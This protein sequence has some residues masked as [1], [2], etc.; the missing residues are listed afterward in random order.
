MISMSSYITHLWKVLIVFLIL[1]NLTGCSRVELLNS[2]ES[3]DTKY[4]HV[5][6]D[7]VFESFDTA[8]KEGLKD[9]FSPNVR[10]DNP[11]LDEQ[12]TSFFEEY[13]SPTVIEEISYSTS[14]G[15]H[16]DH[17]N[18]RTELY[19]SYDIII[20]SGEIRYYIDVELVSRDDFDPDNEGI[21]TLNIS[22]EE[23]HESKYFVNYYSNEDRGGD[24]P[25]FYYQDSTEMRDDIRWIEGMPWRYT[26]YDRDLSVEDLIA[27]VEIND[28]YNNLISVLGEPNC[29]WETYDYYYYE[30]ENNLFAVCKVEDIQTIRPRV[31]GRVTDPDAIV[32]IYIADIEDNIET[33]WMADDI[34][35]V[36]GDY[37][38]FLPVNRELS[39]EFF[40]SFALRSNSLEQLKDEIGSPNIDPYMGW[41]CYYRISENRY[42]DCY[43]MGDVIEKFSVVDSK[44]RLYTIWEAEETEN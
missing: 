8:D 37:Y 43:F 25:G 28:D 29:S 24:K 26:N 35:Q 22:T 36:E 30:I 23:A 21:Q 2:M 11:D 1:S 34:V 32:A 39:E 41:D 10:N 9:L 13:K 14:G 12:I 16:I 27:V 4:F 42:V 19:N 20:K 7:Q 6:M 40:T 5:I 33:V 15:E 18:R 31:N 3:R 38:S 44:E 17:G